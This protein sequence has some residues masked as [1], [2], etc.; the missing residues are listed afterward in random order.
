VSRRNKLA[1]R[2]LKHG[3]LAMRACSHCSARGTVYV[4][5]KL[6]KKCESYVR[7]YRPYDFTSF[8]AEINRLAN[9]DDKISEELLALRAKALRLRR[10]QRRLR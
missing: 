4:L 9:K 1:D 7:L 6:F 8:L 10:E 3:F 5:F 2:I